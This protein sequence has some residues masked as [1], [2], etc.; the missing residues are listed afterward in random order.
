[1]K[2]IN[3]LIIISILLLIGLV[4]F[5]TQYFF[6]KI[7]KQEQTLWLNANEVN[8]TCPIQVD[9]A[10]R[11]DNVTVY[12]NNVYQYNYT[13][14]N[15][16]RA[17][18]NSDVAIKSIEPKIIASIKKENEFQFFRKAQTTINYNY[19]DRNGQFAFKIVI[20]PDKYK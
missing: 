11:L 7:S 3:P 1:M 15:L 9:E 2:K 20:T 12:P 10:T 13:L 17:D 6:P 14:F 4:F 8:K 16:N 5:A 19:K 18:I